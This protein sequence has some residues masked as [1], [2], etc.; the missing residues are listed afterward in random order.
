[1]KKVTIELVEEVTEIYEV[2]YDG[3]MEDFDPI[4]WMTE[5]YL[6]SSKTGNSEYTYDYEV[7]EV[8]EEIDWGAELADIEKEK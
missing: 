6:V 5:K 7:D 1:M 4:E 2:Q 8:I 3:S